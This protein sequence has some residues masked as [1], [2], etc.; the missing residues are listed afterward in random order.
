MFEHI[1][2]WLELR[3]ILFMHQLDAAIHSPSSMLYLPPLGLALL[4]GSAYLV[5]RHRPWE[6]GR[7]PLLAA[8]LGLRRYFMSRSTWVDVGFTVWGVFFFGAVLGWAVVSSAAVSGWVAEGLIMLFGGISPPTIPP[9]VAL[10]LTTLIF[11]LAYEVGYWLD[12]YLKH[13]IRFLWR[14][15]RVHHTAELLTPLTIYRMHPID[16]LVFANVLGAFAGVA[17][18]VTSYLQLGPELAPGGANAIFLFFTFAIVHLQHSHVWIPFT[19]W[20]GRLILS[21]AH[22]QIHHSDAPE[23][24]NKNLGSCLAIWDW[25]FGT[26]EIPSKDQPALR[27][28]A[29]PD[30]RR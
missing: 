20:A 30:A 22:H 4:V 21:P 11:F 14:F 29:E 7:G 25:M 17:Q 28:G 5:A 8:V 1:S 10:T 16:M 26:L 19:G 6:Q 24:F 3:A 13:R 15:H 9:G 23:H 2:R 12:H 18:G 27:F